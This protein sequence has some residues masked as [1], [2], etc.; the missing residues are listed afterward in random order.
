[1]FDQGNTPVE[2]DPD[3]LARQLHPHEEAEWRMTGEVPE[4]GP[5][6]QDSGAGPA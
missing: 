3:A 4:E 5:L 6:S 1:M 2:N